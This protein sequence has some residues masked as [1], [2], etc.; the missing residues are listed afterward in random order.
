MAGE[1]GVAAG[2]AQTPEDAKRLQD[3]I[4]LEAFC[5]YEGRCE[6]KAAG[7]EVGD[8]LA[9]EQAVLGRHGPPAPKAGPGVNQNP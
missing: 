8:W 7:T 1:H 3:E 9:A 2:E 4:R 5:R 6:A